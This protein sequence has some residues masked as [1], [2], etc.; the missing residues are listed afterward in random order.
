MKII[1]I[2]GSPH[3]KGNTYTALA[4]A[5]RIFQMK[6]IEFEIFNIGL[7][8]IRGCVVCGACAKK[9][10]KNVSMKM[11]VLMNVFKK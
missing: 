10:M 11:M 7:K 3:E 8:A 4:A 6:N 9:K 2:N 1:G 5:G